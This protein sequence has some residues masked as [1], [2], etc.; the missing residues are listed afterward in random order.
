MRQ[1]E[2]DPARIEIVRHITNRM[3]EKYQSLLRE[4]PTDDLLKMSGIDGLARSLAANEAVSRALEAI[5]TPKE[6]E[7]AT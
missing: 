4:V 5:E 1:A 7:P 3:V 2:N 6:E